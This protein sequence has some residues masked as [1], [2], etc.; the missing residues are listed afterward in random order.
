MEEVNHEVSLKGCRRIGSRR[1]LTNERRPKKQC[2]LQTVG[3]SSGRI[4][5]VCSKIQ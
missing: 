3:P 5:T 4:R 1:A 2:V